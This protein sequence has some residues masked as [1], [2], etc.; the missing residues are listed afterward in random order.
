MH[1][2]SFIL[3]VIFDS[4]LD[5]KSGDGWTTSKQSEQSSRNIASSR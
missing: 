2:M 3:C 1:L 4:I 5:Q